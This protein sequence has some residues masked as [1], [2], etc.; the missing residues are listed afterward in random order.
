MNVMHHEIGQGKDSINLFA[1]MPC[2]PL[3]DEVEG[4]GGWAGTIVNKQPGMKTVDQFEIVAPR[5]D[6]KPRKKYVAA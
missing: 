3:K 2:P 4:A 1:C 6:Q 5:K